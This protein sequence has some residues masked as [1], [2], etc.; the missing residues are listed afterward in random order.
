[1][2]EVVQEFSK[3]YIHLQNYVIWGPDEETRKIWEHKTTKK[4]AD[5]FE[6]LIG[7]VYKDHGMPGVEKMLKKID[8]YSRVDAIRVKQGKNKADFHIP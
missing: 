8:Y 6:A 5:C 3:D 2:N 7:A 4:L 1:M